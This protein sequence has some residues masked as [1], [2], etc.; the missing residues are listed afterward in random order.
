MPFSDIS[1]ITLSPV[2]DATKALDSLSERTGNA[3]VFARAFEARLLSCLRSLCAVQTGIID[4]SSAVFN[5]SVTEHAVST[6]SDSTFLTRN[7]YLFYTHF[8][9]HARAEKQDFFAKTLVENGIDI[10]KLC[11]LVSLLVTDSLLDQLALI[12]AEHHTALSEHLCF[13][14]VDNVSKKPLRDL[15]FADTTDHDLMLANLALSCLIATFIPSRAKKVSMGKY[16]TSG[17]ILRSAIKYQQDDMMLHFSTPSTKAQKYLSREMYCEIWGLFVNVFTDQV[18]RVDHSSKCLTNLTRVYPYAHRLNHEPR[19]LKNRLEITDVPVYYEAKQEGKTVKKASCCTWLINF[20]KFIVRMCT[21]GLFFSKTEQDDT[22]YSLTRE[23]TSR[24]LH[25]AR[26]QKRQ[27][28]DSLE[29]GKKKARPRSL[30][31]T[32]TTT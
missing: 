8:V 11:K 13:A 31:T 22:K 18:Y 10:T 30:E 4:R 6:I 25:D 3:G 28:I 23:E 5:S 15:S 17:A 9:H 26:M 1:F 32:P 20:F 29:S 12:S 14:I 16:T 24:A 27:Q 2:Y 7:M 19:G 21:M